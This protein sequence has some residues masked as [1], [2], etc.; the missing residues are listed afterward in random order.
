M[1]DRALECRRRWSHS[2][3]V[4][5]R[6]DGTVHTTPPAACVPRLLLSVPYSWSP[7]IFFLSVPLSFFVLT[8]HLP[9]ACP[10]PSFPRRFLYKLNT[11]N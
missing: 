3:G 2:T 4:E 6:I 5:H 8:C 7:I 10:F 9:S 1:V 11:A